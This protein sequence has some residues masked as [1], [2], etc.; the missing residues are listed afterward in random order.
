MKRWA[1]V[2]SVGLLVA[3]VSGLGAQGVPGVD[4][5]PQLVEIV[6]DV[7]VYEGPLA[8]QGEDEI[9]RTNSLVVVTE[10][11]VVVVDG[12]AN[13]EE[14]ERMIEAIGQ[15]TSKPIR[16][17]INASPHGDH[18]NSNPAFEDATILAHEH[19]YEDI[20]ASRAA[21]EEAGS[22]HPPTLPH[23]TF[24][25]FMALR[26]GGRT[27]ELHYFGPGHTR[28]DTV[29]L[30]PDEGVAFLSE[31][32]FNGVAASLGEGYARE[33]LTT[34]ERA[35]ELPAEWWIPGHG[36]VEGQSRQELEAGLEYYYDNVAAIYHAVA[37]RAARGE[38]LDQVLA[39]IAQD[40]G[41]FAELP[42]YHYLEEA[43]IS[44]TYRAATEDR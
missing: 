17:L 13:M 8:L 39:G 24:S 9:V 6:P 4:F 34:L 12:Q 38:S 35:M 16:Y 40:L 14:G 27:F 7:Y 22:P 36:Y 33:H 28:G 10:E 44:A 23:L 18:I 43:T 26:V 5:T 2:T 25:D 1:V 21:A 32:Y 30:L 29:V 31:L 3:G 20:A 42:F 15:V 37:L 11:G 19:A 41:P